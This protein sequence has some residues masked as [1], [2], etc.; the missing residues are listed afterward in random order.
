M[1]NTLDNFVY[2]F[3]F[4]FSLAQDIPWTQM[5]VTEREH[6]LMEGDWDF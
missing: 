3:K 2:I 6:Y 1:L 5:L 4:F